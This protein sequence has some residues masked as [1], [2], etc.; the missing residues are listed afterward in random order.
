MEKQ[1][2][3]RG[4]EWFKKRVQ[5]C[6]K[7]FHRN[8][9]WFT[10][11]FLRF[12]L[13]YRCAITCFV[14]EVFHEICH[15]NYGLY[16]A[17][18]FTASNFSGDAFLKFCKTD[19]KLLTDR[20]YLDLVQRMIRGGRSSVYA[21][22]FYKA[23]NKHL[24]RF[25]ASEPSISILNIGA[26]KLFGVIMKHCLLPLNDFLI[27]EKRLEDILLTAYQ[28]NLSVGLYSCSQFDHTWKATWLLC[29]LPSCPLSWSSGHWCN[30]QR[31]NWHVGKIENHH[32][33]K[34]A[35]ASADLA[36]WKRLCF[37]SP[38]LKVAPRAGNENNSPS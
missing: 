5:S 12:V 34:G 10:C 9:V 24:D 35:N 33:T 8:E 18:Y 26:N 13:D 19:M 36:S 4:C 22:R 21:H 1:S 6:P 2:N 37:A 16:C 11:W 7:N 25:L 29:W 28:R 31:A 38:Y 14:F 27:V 15:Q 3:M 17:C 23:Y 30:E 20:E 32:T